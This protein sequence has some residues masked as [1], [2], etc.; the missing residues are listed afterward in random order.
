MIKDE[1]QRLPRFFEA[2]RPLKIPHE[3]VLVDTGSTDASLALAKAAGAIILKAP[4]E[5]FGATRNRAF[6]SCRAQWILVL[7][8]DE[9]P[10]ATLLS[11][12]EGAVTYG[13]PGLWSVN[14]LPYFLA[15]PVRH[16]GWHP[17]R[18]LR[19]FFKGTA[20]F[21]ERLVHEGL[22]SVFPGVAINS[23]DGMLLHHSYPDLNG[24][25]SR[26]NRYTGL[27]AEECLARKG[28][29][30]KTALARMLADPPFTFLKMYVLKRG[31]MDGWTGL[32]VALLSSFSTLCKYA[33]W[34]Q[35]SLDAG[36]PD[37]REPAR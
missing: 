25:L 19:L 18:Q 9:N 8:A 29:R 15:E 28:R 22:V 1:A 24:Y 34:W 32:L 13:L 6:A 11:E 14:R 21:N 4:W 16:G 3:I 12:I 17:D 27:Q 37:V 36:G 31:F 23:L 2:L 26:L 35:L 7:D 30:P 5:G 20:R 10:D 33:K